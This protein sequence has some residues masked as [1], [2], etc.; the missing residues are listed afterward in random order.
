[1]SRT[2][3]T[4]IHEPPK[5]NET[6]PKEEKELTTTEEYSDNDPDNDDD[7]DTSEVE[8]M[9]RYLEKVDQLLEVKN[10]DSSTYYAIA[11]YMNCIQELTDK[12]KNK[13]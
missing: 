5:N 11:Y 10:P 13:H 7:Y 1:M 12:L 6:D 3:Q 8:E 4:F 2:R 9:S